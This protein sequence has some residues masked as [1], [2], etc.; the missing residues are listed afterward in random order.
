MSYR[1]RV[2]YNISV[3]V[4]RSAS[5]KVEARYTTTSVEIF[6]AETSRFTRG[7]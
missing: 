1:N 4:E 7:Q 3:A 5:H 2:A 6:V